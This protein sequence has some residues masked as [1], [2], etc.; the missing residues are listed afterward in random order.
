[1][2]S[3]E[4][5]L[6][7]YAAGASYIVAH[8]CEST[9]GEDCHCT[10]SPVTIDGGTLA[11][12]ALAGMGTGEHAIKWRGEV[13]RNLAEAGLLKDI[14]QGEDPAAMV[15]MAFDDPELEVIATAITP[16]LVWTLRRA[17][18]TPAELLEAR[19]RGA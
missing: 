19:E 12:Q 2:E 15:A 9:T 13:V 4:R 7:F 16:A 3:I 18:R 11:A 10:F 17:L 8:S 5:V 6:A 14:Y 1:M